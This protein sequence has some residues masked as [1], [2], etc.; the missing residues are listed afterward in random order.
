MEITRTEGIMFQEISEET[1]SFLAPDGRTLKM[2]GSKT[3]AASTGN[4]AQAFHDV[5]HKIGLGYDVE[6]KS[7]IDVW[8]TRIL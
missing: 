8:R 3:V 4:R 7:A 2:P 5:L 6:V 1:P